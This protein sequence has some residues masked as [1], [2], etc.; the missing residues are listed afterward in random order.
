[1]NSEFN[2]GKFINNLDK[3]EK[4]AKK[5]ESSVSDSLDNMYSICFN[6][7]IKKIKENEPLNKYDIE[8]LIKCKALLKENNVFF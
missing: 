5:F 4:F 2:L 7:I 1:M 8:I 3:F 6:N